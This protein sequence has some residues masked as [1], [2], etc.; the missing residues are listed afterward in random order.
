MSSLGGTNIKK[1]N[2]N[3]A[4][5]RILLNKHKN[6]LTGLGAA[7][8]VIGLIAIAQL[9]LNKHRRYQHRVLINQQLCQNGKQEL[10]HFI[11]DG[12]FATVRKNF[13]QQFA[14]GARIPDNLRYNCGCL[15][16]GNEN[17]S[18][19]AHQPMLESQASRY[20]I[21]IYYLL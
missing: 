4:P 1:V 10:L 7:T 5:V 9:C 8:L 12:R 15:F 21:L 14:T 13:Q 3:F 18:Q 17:G 2:L 19:C 16:A 20:L 6:C 11:G